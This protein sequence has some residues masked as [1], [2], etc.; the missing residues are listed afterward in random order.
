MYYNYWNP[1]S[2]TAHTKNLVANHSIIEFFI[3]AHIQLEDQ[4]CL[5]KAI[6]CA[7]SWLECMDKSSGLIPFTNDGSTAW[8][9]PQ[10]DFVVNLLKL[11]QITDDELYWLKAHKILKGILKYHKTNFGYAQKIDIR[12]KKPTTRELETKFLGLMLKPFLYLAA[13]ER[14]KN[15]FDD[16]I[17]KGLMRD[18]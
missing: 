7:K 5:D 1:T 10:I 14:G 2:H 11:Y 16:H 15:I 4:D 3:D 13:I 12:N 18:R 17:L 6:I 8:L 9:D